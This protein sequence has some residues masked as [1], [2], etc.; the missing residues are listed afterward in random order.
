MRTPPS[1]LPTTVATATASPP[2]IPA[3]ARLP[4]PR[5]TRPSWRRPTAKLARSSTSQQPSPP[6]CGAG[7]LQAAL[8]DIEEIGKQAGQARRTLKA[9]IGGMK[10]PAARPGGL[11]EKVAAYLRAHPGSS[12]TPHEI[13]KV[14]DRSSGAIANALDTLVKLGHAELATDK[15]RRFRLVGSAAPAGT[16]TAARQADIGQRTSG[17]AVAGA[18]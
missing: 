2:E 8:A 12:F 9:A 16:P 18:A 14:L 1:P 5:R 17:E 7:D 3:T 13:H 15:P 6:R 11:R 4:E 10:A